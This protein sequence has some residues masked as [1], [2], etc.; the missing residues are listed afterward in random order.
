MLNIAD[1][2]PRYTQLNTIVAEVSRR[3]SIEF[4]QQQLVVDFYTQFNNIQAFEAMLI[5][6]T[7]QAESERYKTLTESLS[8]E[9]QNNIRLISSNNNVL[10]NLNIEETCDKF[11]NQYDTQISDQL[12]ITQQHWK[13][14]SE[15]NNSLD[16]IGFRQHTEQEEIRLWERHETLSE[17]YNSEKTILDEWYEKQ[18]IARKTAEKYRENYFP[19][20]LS[21]SNKLIHYISP[22]KNR[23]VKNKSYFYNCYGKEGILHRKS[24]LK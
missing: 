20:L 17:K 14:L 4:I 7:M 1:I 3:Q 6:L 18:N 19:K 22:Q 16:A 15:V 24:R 23:A 2:L 12:H 8:T 5:S 13:E 10:E 21:L 9:I 11:A